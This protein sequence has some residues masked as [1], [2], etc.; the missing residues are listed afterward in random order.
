M[1]NR[2]IKE[3]IRTS[4]SVSNMTDFQFRLWINLITYVDDYGRG[5]A[6]PEILRS[7]LF[8]RRKRVTESDVEKALAAL[9]DIGSVCLY[10]VDG[11]QYLS[12][13]NWSSHQRVQAKK[14]RFPAPTDGVIHNS[15]VS[16]GELP[17][18][19][20]I[21]NRESE[22]ESESN[23]PLLGDNHAHMHEG[24]KQ[25]KK[26]EPKDEK[27]AYGKFKHV[28]LTVRELEALKQDYPTAWKDY[29][30]RLD[31]YVES[32]GKSYQSHYATILGWMRK[33]GIAPVGSKAPNTAAPSPMAM[34]AIARMMQ[35][36]VP[37]EE[38][39]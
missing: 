26:E 2:I 13:P 37:K 22:S 18:I 21:E 23:I 24:R 32:T 17:P 30:D 11:E 34:N 31:T 10:E 36:T 5:S 1:P 20:G 39:L 35:E 15:T 14:S 12:L 6:D 19:S 16:Y 29:I 9:A 28:L 25:S 4:R 7:F 33:D 27:L 38:T 8:P 3:S